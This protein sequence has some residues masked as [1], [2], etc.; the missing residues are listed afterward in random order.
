MSGFIG[1]LSGGV[2]PKGLLNNTGRDYRAYVHAGELAGAAWLKERSG[3]TPVYAGYFGNNRLWVAG[4]DRS[5][6]FYNEILPSAIDTRAYVYRDNGEI[7]SNTAIIN[8]RGTFLVYPYPTQA[9]EKNKNT[10]YSN[11]QVKVYK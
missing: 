11:S 5:T 4:F 6:N 1:Q 3:N 7:S 8:Y 2:N 9:L 10:I